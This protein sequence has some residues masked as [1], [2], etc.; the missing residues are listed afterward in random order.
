MTMRSAA[1]LAFVATIT[2]GGCNQ[3]S[4]SRLDDDTE[5]VVTVPTGTA[6]QAASEQ[7]DEASAE[8]PNTASPLSLT[9]IVGIASLAGAAVV[10]T[11][12]RR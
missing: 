7:R 8:L 10:R 5:A 2:A 6:G 1:I 4:E 12:R 9:G 3:A 11:L